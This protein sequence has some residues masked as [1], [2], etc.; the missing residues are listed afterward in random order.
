MKRNLIILALVVILAMALVV[1]PVMADDG[2]PNTTFIADFYAGIAPLTV[3]FNDTTLIN[4]EITEWNWSYTNVTPGNNTPV[5]WS[6][7][8][9]STCTFGVGNFSIA[10]NATNS[11]GFNLS[12]QVT[13]INVSWPA[14]VASFTPS[15]TSG[16]APLTVTFADGSTNSP[17]GWA[18]NATNVTGN[19]TPFTFSTLQSPPQVF[20]V[21][22]FSISLMAT[23]S[24]GSNVSTQVTFINVSAPYP[25]F[26][27]ITPNS[28]WTSGGTAVTI[29]GANFTAGGLF[30]VTIGGRGAAAVWISATTIT[31]TTPYGIA[32]ARDVVITNNDGQTAIGTGAYTYVEPPEGGGDDGPPG[33]APATVP[34]IVPGIST[35][36]VV[37][38]GGNSA[39]TQVAITGT[40]ISGA[41]V[42]SIVVIGPGEGNSPPPGDVYEYMDITPAQFTTIDNVVI[43]FT[44]PVS[45]LEEHHLTPQ[46]IIMYHLVGKTWN[47]LP[48]TLVKTENGHAYFTAVSPGLSRFA[49]AGD[50][51]TTEA[52]QEQTFGDMVP[53]TPAPVESTVAYTPIVTQTTA[54]PVTPTPT[55]KSGIPGIS[56][57]LGTVGAI[58][59]VAGAGMV[60]RRRIRR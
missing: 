45:W 37:N 40:G 27:S 48:T 53:V 3:Q 32:G 2:P 26:T 57:V 49:I 15:V 21:G 9:N 33:W 47:A 46:N 28:G 60:R 42:T 25:T 22:N 36:N 7:V 31:A 41:I 13:F 43:S 8:Q 38:V 5:W 54:A 39:V 23:N 35:T 14:P 55:V 29:L 30:S 11:F 50:I 6:I 20:G 52:I 19:N 12:T 51:S 58:V 4:N 18:W 34:V 1:A 56:L 24:G 16:T 17:T 59:L 44:V 10:L